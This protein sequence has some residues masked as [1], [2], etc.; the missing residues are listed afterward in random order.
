MTH[1]KCSFAFLIFP[2]H[3]NTTLS[4]FTASLDLIPQPSSNFRMRAATVILQYVIPELK[5]THSLRPPEQAKLSSRHTNYM[6]RRS[7]V[8]A[9]VKASAATSSSKSSSAATAA[10]E[11]T[12][13][14]SKVVVAAAAIEAATSIKAP[15]TSASKR[16]AYSTW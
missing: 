14:T 7:L 10:S 15:P 13:S 1:S 11:I 9:F 6:F 3:Y 2:L 8:L 16:H 12:A 4:Q 5:Q